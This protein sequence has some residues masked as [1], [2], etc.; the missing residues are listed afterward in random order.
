MART[1]M[2]RIR[3]KPSCGHTIITKT[4]LTIKNYLKHNFSKNVW[5]FSSNVI[6]Y[7]KNKTWA[8]YRKSVNNKLVDL[9]RFNRFCSWI[10]GV[11]VVFFFTNFIKQ[12]CYLF[13]EIKSESGRSIE[14]WLIRIHKSFLAEQLFFFDFIFLNI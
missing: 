7:D 12:F 2:L 3:K 6:F 10:F 4:T 1:Q 9:I 13:L 8:P 14:E 5:F 11:C